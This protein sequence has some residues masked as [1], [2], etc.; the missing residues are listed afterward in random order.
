M[1]AVAAPALAGADGYLR[2]G[3]PVALRF[4]SPAPARPPLNEAILALKA[5]A[6]EVKPEPDA[7]ETPTTSPQELNATIAAL[8]SRVAA[9]GSTLTN[10][11]PA[12]ATTEVVDSQLTPPSTPPA[13]TPA[14]DEGEAASLLPGILTIFNTK[15]DARNRRNGAA[16]VVPST[17]FNPPQPA[18]TGSRAVYRSE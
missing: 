9:L 7:V 6:K 18:T 12:V 17:I 5:P 4:E 2:Q 13:I 11:T 8:I 14:Q 3:A 16:V 10:E 15:D 1:L